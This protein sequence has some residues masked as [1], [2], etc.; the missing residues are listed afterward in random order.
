M[1]F[2]IRNFQNRIDY[3]TIS[4]GLDYFKEQRVDFINFNKNNN[5]I[6]TKVHGP[7][8]HYN[9]TLHFKGEEVIYYHC[10]CPVN[11]MCKHIVATL[12]QIEDE[13]FFGEDKKEPLIVDSLVDSFKK[14][15]SY[16]YDKETIFTKENITLLMD[17]I[18]EFISANYDFKKKNDIEYLAETASLFSF[19]GFNNDYHTFFFDALLTFL[20]DYQ[21]I[22]STVQLKLIIMQSKFC[23]KKNIEIQSIDYTKLNSILSEELYGLLV[24]YLF[25]LGAIKKETNYEFNSKNFKHVFAHYLVNNFCPTIIDYVRNLKNKLF[26]KAYEIAIEFYLNDN[27]EN[28]DQLDNAIKCIGGFKHSLFYIMEKLSSYPHPVEYVEILF[29]YNIQIGTFDCAINYNLSDFIEKVNVLYDLSDNIL[30]LTLVKRIKPDKDD[31]LYKIFNGYGFVVENHLEDYNLERYEKVFLSDKEYAKNIVKITSGGLPSAL[32]NHLLDI[33]T[34][35]KYEL[36]KIDSLKLTKIIK[37][38]DGKVTVFVIG[39]NHFSFILIQD[40][41]GVKVK[42]YTPY[43]DKSIIEFLCQQPASANFED[44]FNKIMDDNREIFKEAVKTEKIKKAKRMIDQLQQKITQSTL[45]VN[46]KKSEINLILNLNSSYA[47]S[48]YI[49]LENEFSLNLRIGYNKM[50]LIKNPYN[51]MRKLNNED[52][53]KYGKE[54]SLYHISDNFTPTGKQIIEVLHQLPAT[55]TTADERSIPIRLIS[56]LVSASTDTPIDI[57]INNEDGAL[58]KTFI[59]FTPVNEPLMMEI[60]LDENLKP[61][62]KNN[63]FAKGNVIIASSIDDYFINYEERTIHLVEYQ[64]DKQKQIV[65]FFLKFDDIDLQYAI[66]DFKTKI[67]PY[68]KSVVKLPKQIEEEINANM[69]K[70]K[71]YIDFDQDKSK[72]KVDTKIYIGEKEINKPTSNEDKLTMQ[73]YDKLLIE[74]GFS[75]KGEISND[76]EIYLFLNKDI[77]LLKE[78]ATVFV[79]ENVTRLSTKKVSKF[80][81]N[82]SLIEG[83][84]RAHITSSDLTDEEINAILTKYK[85]GVRYIF[86]KSNIIDT[87]DA[88]VKVAL[89]FIQD[90]DLDP[91]KNYK[92]LPLHHLFKIEAYDENNISIEKDKLIEEVLSSIKNFKKSNYRPEEKFTK[93]MKSYQIDGFKWLSTLYKHGLGG[94]LADDMGLGKTLQILAL[95][96]SI[97]TTK[98]I[99]VVCPKA[100]VYNWNKE[101]EK[102]ECNIKTIVYNGSV[103]ERELLMEEIIASKEKTM[104]IVSYDTLRNDIELFDKIHFD[105]VILDEVQ[106]IKSINAKRTKNVKL[107]KADHRFALT[108]TPIENSVADIWSIFDFLMPKY[109][110][111]RTNFTAIEKAANELQDDG[112]N[113]VINKTR[114]FILRRIKKDVLKDLPPKTEELI[115]C[116][117]DDKSKK[118]YDARLGQISKVINSKESSAVEL[119]KGL[120]SLRQICISPA[121]S[122]IYDE[123]SPKVAAVLEL[124]EQATLSGHKILVFSSFVKGLDEVAKHLQSPHFMITG[125]TSAKLRLELV[126]K[127]NDEKEPTSVFLISLKAGGV[128]LNLTGADIVIHLD[129]WWNLAA[130]NQATDRAHRIGQTKHV[131][132]YKL[133][134]A[135]SIEAKIIDIQ[136]RKKDIFDRVIADN[137][138][139]IT[140]L[141]IND[142]KA[143]ILD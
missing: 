131:V 37:V 52:F 108:G 80:T 60:E 43:S 101:V 72:I 117:F 126:D 7:N 79:S 137:E 88:K 68:V 34:I 123:V 48:K 138:E 93:I 128:G 9:V 142:Y 132:V 91:N 135:K 130:E 30:Y 38:H 45:K 82:V 3:N 31:P 102:F 29:N 133:I 100:L 103:K 67:I 85:R 25:E 54:L 105:T 71:T 14:K 23:L 55:L 12:F 2:T 16:L 58:L 89:D 97:K 74:Y 113:F 77:S 84:L 98:P 44:R 136:K 121:L 124:I 8:S 111:N 17:N 110:P 143:L 70:I 49:E 120:M 36:F 42:N 65:H 66:E 56:K 50:Y 26:N 46:V 112:L 90:F 24:Y 11:G 75:S 73:N 104:A 99:L 116:D 40:F 140:K 6:T 115:Y 125:D 95:L 33:K 61:I 28:Y 27:K 13:D 59:G 69:F 129:P 94:I 39:D 53:H 76:Q 10:S 19:A 127:F 81:A 64:N 22:L 114:P 87:T 5:I 62:F 78:Y 32:R 118:I 106:H 63:L 51:F 119:L 141:S 134:M 122:Y 18:R 1:K 96:E 86:L 107:V 83:Y 92:Q 41:E 15:F 35:Q 4:K 21:D 20:N 109:L 47:S 139:G 57:S